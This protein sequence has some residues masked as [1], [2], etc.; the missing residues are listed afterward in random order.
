MFAENGQAAADKVMSGRYDLV[1]M[2]VQMPVMDGYT[3]TRTIRSW[4][5]ETNSTPVPI[6]ALTAHALAEESDNAREAGCTAHLTKPVRKLTL[7]SAIEIHGRGTEPRKARKKRVRAIPGLEARTPQY[8]QNR[9][10]DIENIAQA[11]EQA[12]FATIQRLGHN[13]AGSGAGYGFPEITEIGRRMESAAQRASLQEMP[14]LL[15][16]L[17]AY[18]AELEVVYE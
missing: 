14:K 2:D 6:I 12:D 1:L 13:M 16:D 15:A 8:L 3:A 17:T 18:M 4:E 10:Q 9:Q 11:I 7:L 5:R